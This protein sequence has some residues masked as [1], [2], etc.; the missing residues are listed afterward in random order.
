[1]QLNEHPLVNARER[2]RDRWENEIRGLALQALRDD[3]RRQV[4]EQA[5]RAGIIRR[6]KPVL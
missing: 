4:A 3:E 5:E 1:M 2:E 6:L